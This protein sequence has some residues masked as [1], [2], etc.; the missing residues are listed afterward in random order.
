MKE[1]WSKIDSAPLHKWIW[2]YS[3]RYHDGPGVEK[4]GVMQ[5]YVSIDGKF[6]DDFGVEVMWDFSHWTSIP[7]APVIE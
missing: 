2:M 7:H 1:L 5:G 3:K 6:F 4:N